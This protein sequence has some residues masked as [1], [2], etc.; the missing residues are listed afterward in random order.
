MK[1]KERVQLRFII[2][3]HV[4]DRDLMVKIQEFFG[5]GHL[6]RDTDTKVQYRMNGMDNLEMKL[7]PLLDKYPLQTKKH[8][9]AAIFRTIYTMMREKQ[10]LT[11]EGLSI[12]KDL[13]SKMNRGR[14]KELMNASPLCF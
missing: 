6:M 5:C 2:T 4:Q 10:H 9:D 1:N 7:F 14:I 3:Q 12:I 8:L 13:K 11:P